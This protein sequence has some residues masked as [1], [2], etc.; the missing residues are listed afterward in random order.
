MYF[1][2]LDFLQPGVN[3]MS[4]RWLVALIGA[5]VPGVGGDY[6]VGEEEEEE[7]E[8]RDSFNPD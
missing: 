3:G 5:D 1:A 2:Y 4:D 6:A 8:R 7:V